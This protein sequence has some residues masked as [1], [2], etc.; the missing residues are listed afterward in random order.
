MMSRPFL[1]KSRI[2]KVFSCK[3]NTKHGHFFKMS[4]QSHLATGSALEGV[5]LLFARLHKEMSLHRIRHLPCM[6][7]INECPFQD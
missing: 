3:K 2:I 1:R 7:H 6:H 5:C 4:M